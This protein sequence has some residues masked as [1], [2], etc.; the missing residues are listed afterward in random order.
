MECSKHQRD[1]SFPTVD[2]FEQHWTK[3]VDLLVD[4]SPGY[5]IELAGTS[6]WNPLE[7]SGSTHA[8]SCWFASLDCPDTVQASMESSQSHPQDRQSRNNTVY[9]DDNRP[10]LSWEQAAAMQ[11]Y[12]FRIELLSAFLG[13][14]GDGLN[15]R[16]LDRPV[17]F[18]HPFVC[19]AADEDRGE[20]NAIDQRFSPSAYR[21]RTRLN[22]TEAARRAKHREGLEP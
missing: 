3:T 11:S 10:C 1:R 5:K 21:H 20:R 7:S 4:D 19:A 9:K 2:N 14:N 6:H 22:R 13:H 12:L 18:R 17:D 16:Q 15:L 8:P